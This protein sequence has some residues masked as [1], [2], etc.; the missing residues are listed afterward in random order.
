MSLTRTTF[1]KW[2]AAG[3]VAAGALFATASASA[4]VGWSVGVNVPGVAI[5]V[6]TPQ[7]YYAPAPVYVAPAPVY[8]PPPPVYY[9]PAPVYYAP[10]AAYYRPA[11]GYYRPGPGYYR[12]H[13][14][15]YYR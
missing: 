8:Y 11:P 3:V 1:F 5:G 4:A 9:R 12:H 15:G 14:H 2:A 6:A 13:G 7:P 10:P